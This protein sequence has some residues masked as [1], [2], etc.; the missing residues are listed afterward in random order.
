METKMIN[1]DDIFDKVEKPL[2]PH[3]TY[4][5]E[6]VTEVEIGRRMKIAEELERLGISISK[7]DIK[8][9]HEDEDALQAII[10]ANQG[11][12]IPEDLKKRLMEKNKM[13]QKKKKVGTQPI[14]L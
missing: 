9:E 6:P 7:F 11:K 4:G 1:I 12:E 3:I 13:E 2:T 8:D 5:Q 10:Y 14:I